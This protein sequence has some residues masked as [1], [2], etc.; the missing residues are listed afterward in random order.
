MV[1]AGVTGLVVPPLDVRALR[2]G[3]IQL[4]QDAEGQAAMRARCRH[5]AVSEYSLDIQ[6]QRYAVLYGELMQ[7]PDKGTSKRRQP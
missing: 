7:T 4:L 3:I 6:A 1:R 5:F 2:S